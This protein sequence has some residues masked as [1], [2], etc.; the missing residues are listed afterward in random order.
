MSLYAITGICLIC[1]LLSTAWIYNLAVGLPIDLCVRY[2]GAY[3][4]QNCTTL[5][6]FGVPV[7]LRVRRSLTPTQFQ[8]VLLRSMGNHLRDTSENLQEVCQPYPFIIAP[9]MHA[10]SRLLCLL[11]FMDSSTLLYRY[12][13]SFV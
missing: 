6:R 10:Y 4:P 13:R 7:V 9:C 8:S 1:F 2:Y 5:F 3:Q 12:N 11:A